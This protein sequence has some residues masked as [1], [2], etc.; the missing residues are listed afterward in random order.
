MWTDINENFDWLIWLPPALSVD[1]QHTSPCPL[2]S[3]SAVSSGTPVLFFLQHVTFFLLD[4]PVGTPVFRVGTAV[5]NKNSH[6]FHKS[7]CFRCPICQAPKRFEWVAT[8]GVSQCTLYCSVFQTANIIFVR[9]QMVVALT[10]PF[11]RL[12][13][14]KRERERERER[15]RGLRINEWIFLLTRVMQ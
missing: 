1:G 14:R 9:R 2:V 12:S 5:T 8:I 11:L 13:S 6:Q 3:P 15:E 4:Q 7:V 10:S